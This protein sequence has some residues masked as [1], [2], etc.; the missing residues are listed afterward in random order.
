[1]A[2]TAYPFPPLVASLQSRPLPAAMLWTDAS[3]PSVSSYNVIGRFSS[4]RTLSPRNHEKGL[5]VAPLS[6]KGSR[7]KLGGILFLDG[8]FF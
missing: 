8:L 6:T 5:L 2:A 1:M 3:P 4:W 7:L